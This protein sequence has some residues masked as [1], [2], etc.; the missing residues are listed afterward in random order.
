[1]IDSHVLDETDAAIVAARLVELDGIDG[2]RVGDWVDFADGESR[3]IAHI[4]SNRDIWTGL[5]QPVSVQT[6]DGIGSFYL[7][8]GYVSM[9]GALHPGVD[10]ILLTDTGKTR[11]GAVWIFH[12]DWHRAHN[13]V[14]TVVPFR[15]FDCPVHAP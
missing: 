13:G 6:T 7:G 14:D 5:A 8:D 10:P 1:M 9:S 3:R 2:P 4:W 15:V 12:H 11:P